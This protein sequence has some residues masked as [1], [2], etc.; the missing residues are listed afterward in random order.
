MD[1]QVPLNR[2]H[3]GH[4]VGDGINAR[5]AGRL[6]G[7]DAL[8]A[9]IFARG[10]IENLVVYHMFDGD[11]GVSNGNRRLAALHLIHGANNDVLINCT[12][13]E[14]DETQAFEDSLTT[15]VTARQL[16]P[17]DQYEAFARLEGRGKTNEEIARQ[18]GMTEKEVRQALALGRLSPKIREAWRNGE[19]KREVA[20]A[21]TLA[22]D[23][24]TQDKAFAK[25]SKAGKMW[26]SYV[27]DELGAANV[28]VA[29][30]LD[31]VGTDRYRDAG[32]SVVEDLFGS[33]HVVSDP[34]LLKEMA[35]DKL[36]ATCEHLRS[37]GWSWAT[38]LSDLP[39]GSRWWKR[40]EPKARAYE[41]DEAD[42][43]TALRAAI[44]RFENDDND[45]NDSYD[46][47][48]QRTAELAELE[49]SVLRRSYTDRQKAK[50]GCIV[51][52]EDGRLV[53]LFGVMRPDELASVASDVEPGKAKSPEA[54]APA[55]PAVSNALSHRLTV[56]L[57]K[58]AGTALMQDPD[59]ALSVM[60]AGFSCY[61]GGGL[62]INVNG[63]EAHSLD[64]LGTKEVPQALAAVMKLDMT[65]R[66]TLL[67]EVA[68][69]ALDFQNMPL[70]ADKNDNHHGAG[71]ICN[72]LD[73][74]ALNAAL[75]GVFDAKDYFSG[76]NEALCLAAIEE[77]LGSDL[78]RQQ[79]KNP[80]GDIAAFAS[81]NVPVTGWLPTQLRAKGY[82]GPPVVKAAIAPDKKTAVKPAPAKKAAV[83]K[84][85]AKSPT[86]A[87][88]KPKTAKAAK[89]KTA[90]KKA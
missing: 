18:Y 78:A 51:D 2:L 38:L 25:L 82:D 66:M 4:E 62:K 86:K 10:Q 47:N 57:T 23:H 12:R 31:F 42:R 81:A 80:K 52:L 64:L 30:L 68:A 73:A 37:E 65:A 56:Q 9:N 13:R 15:A 53:I 88:A 8:A 26:E 32:G 61:D 85:A 84:V 5:V 1:I 76:V 27:K 74:K 21:F 60:L 19:I 69:A 67:A 6:E 34:A 58:A 39:S 71:A 28:D 48:E 89:K 87:K 36:N 59:L 55:E 22:L 72:I 41:G 63:L 11:Y 49:Q 45:D 29:E 46:A 54:A 33:G 43:A 40:S 20:Q 3:F 17:V 50:A 7:I 16:H 79:A 75:R 14:V 70:D 83:K 77:A 35:A 90:K 44:E 24:K